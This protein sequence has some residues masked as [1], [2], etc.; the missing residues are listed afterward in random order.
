MANIDFAL[1]TVHGAFW[2]SFGIARLRSRSHDS[3]ATD[4]TVPAVS[5][6]HEATAPHSRAL[7]V[8]HMTA[9]GVMYFGIGNALF[10]VRVPR[11]F[12]GQQIAGTLIIASGAVLMAW[13]LTYFRSWRFR[14]KLDA[15]HELATGGP[16]RYLRHPLYMGLNLLALGSA[17][18]V[19]TPTLWVSCALMVLGSDL[20][21]RA[22]E[23]LL[24]QGFG[25]EYRK[26]AAGTRRFIPGVY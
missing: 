5:V 11:W 22:E 8:L 7:V 1:Y 14:A 3:A 20:R 9:F 16:F 2:T 10:T 18:W 4:D 17:V 24:E 23:S 26:Y 6:A 21:G 25:A 12:P 13:A 15:G 19:P